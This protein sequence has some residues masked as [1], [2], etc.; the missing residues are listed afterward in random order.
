MRVVALRLCVIKVARSRRSVHVHV[1]LHARQRRGSPRCTTCCCTRCKN[2]QPHG[3]SNRG[4]RR[5]RGRTSRRERSPRHVRRTSRCKQP[6]RRPCAAEY[7][8][9]GGWCPTG[10]G[11]ARRAW[12]TGRGAARVCPARACCGVECSRSSEAAPT[13]GEDVA[14][15]TAAA[16][17]GGGS[18]EPRA[19]TWSEDTRA[20][21]ATLHHVG[22]APHGYCALRAGDVVGLL[23]RRRSPRC[24]GRR[25]QADGSGR[26][27]SDQPQLYE[28]RWLTAAPA[29]RQECLN[30]G[31]G[32]GSRLCGWCAGPSSPWGH[33]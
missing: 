22:S 17:W 19:A 25:A 15:S 5:C 11:C 20:C 8:R 23:R 7:V 30:H 26:V 18:C 32:S 4:A 2:V 31:A 10:V 16:G 3:R 33:R 1:A 13:T 28:L 12:C 6:R 24:R 27:K 21:A 14:Q 9:D 29:T